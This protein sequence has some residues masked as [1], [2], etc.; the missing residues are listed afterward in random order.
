M[1]VF[2]PHHKV[3]NIYFDEINKYATI[4][5]IY[6]KLEDYKPNYEIVNIQFPEAIFAFKVPTKEQ[7][8][9]LE[10]L[11]LI[12]KIKSKIVLTLN[13]IES[14]Y[15]KGNKFSTL[16]K[17]LYKYADGVIHLGNYSLNKYQS[18]FAEKCRHKL[19]NHPLYDSLL[20]TKE[21][22]DFQDKFKVDFQ[23][24]YVVSAI[25]SFRSMEEVRLLLAIFNKIPVKNKFLVVPNMLQFVKPKYFRPY[26]FRNIYKYISEKIICFPLKKEQYFFDN[27]FLEYGYM[28]D[29]VRNSSLIIIPRIKNLNSGNLFLGLTYDKPMVIPKIGNLTEVAEYFDLPTLD[30]K[31]RNY[32]EVLSIVT[33]EKINKI[34]KSNE[35]LNKK[36]QFHPKKISKEYESFFK[37]L[38]GI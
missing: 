27:R 31:K 2:I 21:V 34:F 10:E 8:I 35:Y 4:D 20:N 33:D 12:W 29:L 18:I 23:D 30:L 32:N 24:K 26:R 14:H 37:T 13:D 7:L 16:F 3:L 6:G 19:I 11:F 28:T 15:D 5:Y 9:D 17:L 38:G 36:E 22:F 1:K 25:G